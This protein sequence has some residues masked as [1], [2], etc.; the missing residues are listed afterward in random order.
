[1]RPFPIERCCNGDRA[2]AQLACDDDRRFA[3]AMRQLADV[4]RTNPQRVAVFLQ[5]LFAPFAAD[6]LLRACR[7]L[8]LVDVWISCAARYCAALPTRDERR[9]F[10]GYIRWHVDDPEYARLTERHATEWHQLRAGR[11]TGTTRTK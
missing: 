2:R 11:A 9:N 4:A 5:P 3:C 7:S 8:S 6:M 1:M 10:F